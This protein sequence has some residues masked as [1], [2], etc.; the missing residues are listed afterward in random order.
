MDIIRIGMMKNRFG[1]R[2]VVRPMSID[3]TTLTITEA[4]DLDEYGDGDDE[5]INTL[6]ALAN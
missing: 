4:E 6:A 1:V 3:Y 2:G 5:G